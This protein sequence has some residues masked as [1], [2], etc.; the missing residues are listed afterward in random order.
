MAWAPDYVTLSEARDFER[1]DDADTFDDVELQTWITA[2]SRAA[3]HATGRQ[4]GQTDGPVAFTY[5]D[6]DVYYDCH[7][8]LW[9]VNTDDFEG[10]VTALV[11]GVAATPVGYEPRNAVAKG[12]PRTR[13]LF[14]ADG[15]WWSTPAEW[16]LT[17]TW[18]RSAVPAAVVGAVK[19]QI[20]RW[21][22]RRDSPYGIAGSPDQGS[23]LRLLS[24]LDPDVAVL[25]SSCE[26]KARPR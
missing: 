1:I 3:D 8:D 11:D 18:G 19:L 5:T 15:L 6:R 24:R 20:S 21:A 25:L 13:V 12:E 16:V 14:A 9:V 22:A 10:E 26:R 2:A 4:F 23:E 17:T 7:R